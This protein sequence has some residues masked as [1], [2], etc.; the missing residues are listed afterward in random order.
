MIDGDEPGDGIV[1]PNLM[2]HWGSKYTSRMRRTIHL[3]YR[4]FGGQIF[5]YHHHLDWYHADGFRQHLSP[6]A[7]AQFAHWTECYDQECDQIETLFRALIARDEPKFR[8]CLAELHPGEFGRMVSV[9]LMCRIA[10]KV[11]FGCTEGTRDRPDVRIHLSAS[12]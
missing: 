8:A 1:Y 9:V 6:A 11:V 12:R 7:A 4:S 5:S 2:M 10:N 3:G